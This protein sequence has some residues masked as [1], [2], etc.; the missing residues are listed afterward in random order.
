MKKPIMSIGESCADLILKTSFSESIQAKNM[1]ILQLGSVHED[2]DQVIF[3]PGGSV[4]NTAT[5][6]ASL[7][8]KS[9]F[10]SHGGNDFFGHKIKAYI[11]GKGV[12]TKYYTFL[13]DA[14]SLMV[15]CLV[16]PDGERDFRPFPFKGSAPSR[17][18]DTDF[19][20]GI[21]NEISMMFTS[22]VQLTEEPVATAVLHFMARCHEKGIPIAFDVNLRTNTFGWDEQMK[23][24]FSRALSLADYIFGSATEELPQVTG[25]RTVQEAVACLL[26]DYNKVVVAKDGANGATAY[27]QSDQIFFPAFP[28]KVVDTI[29]AGDTFNGGFL[30]A[31]YRNLSLAQCMAWGTAAAAYSLGFEGSSTQPTPADIAAIFQSHEIS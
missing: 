24:R 6:I 2:P 23:S 20:P 14:S 1:D 7:G 29:G 30:A 5:V 16:S 10:F 25:T 4:S 28:V 13:D 19:F 27:T 12:D 15:F 26:H 22:G 8:A 21:E 31:W 3:H 9:S 18:M 17:I 11:Q